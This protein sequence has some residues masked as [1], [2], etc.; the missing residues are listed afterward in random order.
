MSKGW[1]V[2]LESLGSAVHHPCMC[3]VNNS[4]P[5]KGKSSVDFALLRMPEACTHKTLHI[6]TT[7][8]MNPACVSDA[9]VAA[10]SNV[11]HY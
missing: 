7:V 1:S 11:F 6:V 8:V 2:T 9:S 3:M 5:L 10:C 4:V